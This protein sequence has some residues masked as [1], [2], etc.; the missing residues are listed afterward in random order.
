MFKNVL[1]ECIEGREG[2]I[3]GEGEREDGK[4]GSVESGSSNWKIHEL[5]DSRAVS[6]FIL[7]FFLIH[8]ILMQ[9]LAILGN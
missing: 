5:S 6:L 3:N 8:T 2:E 9:T 1:D 7:F 4:R